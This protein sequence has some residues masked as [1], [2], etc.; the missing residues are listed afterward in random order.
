MPESS[1]E[2]RDRIRSLDNSTS[3]VLALDV[4]EAAFDALDRGGDPDTWVDDHHSS[5]TITRSTAD[6]SL[7]VLALGIAMDNEYREGMGGTALGFASLLSELA[8]ELT[9]ARAARV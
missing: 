5:L 4:A 2:R 3:M 8:A 1:L 7:L 6:W 9:A